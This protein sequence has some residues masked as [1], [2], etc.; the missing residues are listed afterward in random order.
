MYVGTIVELKMKCLGNNPGTIGVVFYDYGDGIQVIF[1]NGEYDG[2]SNKGIMID[3]QTECE[4]FLKEIGFE[5]LLADYMFKNVIQVN[6][7]FRNGVF[8]SIFKRKET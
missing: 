8:D 3:S 2:F 6:E 1:E 4:Y 7:D 5:P